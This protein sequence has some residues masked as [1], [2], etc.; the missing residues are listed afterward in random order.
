MGRVRRAAADITYEHVDISEDLEG[1]VK[2]FTYTDVASGES[3]S[4]SL[5]VQDRERKWMGG[6]APKKEDHLSANLRFMDWEQD[7]DNWGMYCGEFVVDD[8]TMSGPPAACEIKAVSIPRQTAFNEEERTKNWESVTVQEIA[9]EIAGRA[10]ISLFY[11][12]EEIR[13]VSLEQDRQTDCKFLYSVCEKYGLAMKV[14]AEKIII[15]DEAQYESAGPVDTLHYGDFSQYKYNSTLAGT[16]TG[17]KIAY[18]DPGTGEEHMVEVGDGS[19]V[20]E[21]NGEADSPADAQ[22]KATASLNNANKKAE[23]FSGTV[24]ARRGLAATGCVEIEGFGAADGIYYMDKVTTKIGGNGASVQMLEMHRT[25]YRMDG[26][27]VTVDRKQEGTPGGPAG[28]YTVV[29]GDTLWTIAKQVLGS[30]LRYAE[31]YSLNRETIESAAR[32]RGKRDSG[33]G[34]W[35]FAG[36]VLQMP[37]AEGGA[38]DAV[39]RDTE[40]EDISG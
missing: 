17:A 9:S 31:I 14:F 21:I 40:R 7:G 36:T 20:M 19:R 4:V 28:G 30:A 11:E 8:V 6:W 34:H 12:A 15:F 16:Y 35:I 13:V 3:D 5:C 18:S 2:L 29:K 39:Q 33:N 24:K 23:T 38:G 37:A 32:G 22:K 26:A 25:G 1:C 27:T 10:G